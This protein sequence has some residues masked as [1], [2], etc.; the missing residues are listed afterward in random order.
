M[1][2]NIDRVIVKKWKKGKQGIS[3]KCEW[4]RQKCINKTWLAENWENVNLIQ[5]L[6]PFAQGGFFLNTAVIL[7][8]TFFFHTNNQNII[9]YK[10]HDCF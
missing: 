3:P 9:T 4:K 1:E 5:L 2:Y 8:N 7:L 6:I 10:N